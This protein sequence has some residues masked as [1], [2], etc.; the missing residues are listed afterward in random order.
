M[1][2]SFD[3]YLRVLVRTMR[4]SVSIAHCLLMMSSRCLANLSGRKAKHGVVHMLTIVEEEQLPLPPQA[5]Q[6][7][8]AE[9]KVRVISVDRAHRMMSSAMRSSW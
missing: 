5:L 6:D 9:S 8:L 4:S 1:S 2:K 3:R 7:C